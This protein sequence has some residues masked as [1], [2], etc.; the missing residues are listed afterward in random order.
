MRR[1][2]TY[3]PNK[4]RTYTYTRVTV[5]TAQTKEHQPYMADQRNNKQQVETCVTNHQGVAFQANDSLEFCG[6][7]E[8]KNNIKNKQQQ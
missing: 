8:N 2:R 6:L 7:D 4:K 3:V 5:S 1:E